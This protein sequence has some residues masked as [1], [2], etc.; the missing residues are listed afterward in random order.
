ME[1][2]FTRRN[3]VKSVSAFAA[4]SIFPNRIISQVVNKPDSNFNGVQIGVITYSWRGMAGTADDLLGY[5]IQCGLS[6]VEIMSGPVEEFAGAPT[7]ERIPWR[8][9][10]ELTEEQRAQIYR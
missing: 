4:L 7:F 3:F 6:S 10:Q 2:Q 5:L 9:G 1:A 8:R